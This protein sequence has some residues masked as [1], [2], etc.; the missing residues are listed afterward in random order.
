M[1]EPAADLS[2]SPEATRFAAIPARMILLADGQSWGLALP[3]PRYRPEVVAGIDS[4]RRP[5]ETIRLVTRTGYPAPLERLIADL[6]AAC[7][8]PDHRIADTRRFETLMA[9]AVA[10]LRRAHDLTLPAA[11]ALLDLDDAGLARL[12]DVVL[13]VVANLRL[14]PAF[15][16]ISSSHGGGDA[17]CS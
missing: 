5:V 13:D 10:L 12:V 4:L 15:G 3:T 9:L 6:R 14:S 11:V 1:T 8:D 17:C 7:L 2:L 16:S